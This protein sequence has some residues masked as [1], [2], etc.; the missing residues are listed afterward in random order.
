MVRSW[1]DYIAS[2]A[3]PAQSLGKT[4]PLV[5]TLQQALA[6]LLKDVQLHLVRAD[7]R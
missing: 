6:K 4:S 3:R 1:L 5:A 2:Q 7:K